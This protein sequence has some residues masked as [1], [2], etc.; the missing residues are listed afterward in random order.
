MLVRK[1]LTSRASPDEMGIVI[2]VIAMIAAVELQHSGGI[3]AQSY[4]LQVSYNPC[5]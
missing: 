3:I 2:I 5:P 4:A 1:I